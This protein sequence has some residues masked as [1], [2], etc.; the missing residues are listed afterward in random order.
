VWDVVNQFISLSFTQPVQTWQ[1]IYFFVSWFI[2][3]LLINLPFLVEN[4]FV[5]PGFSV[6]SQNTRGHV[7]VS[8]GWA[9][10]VRGE[11][12]RG[13]ASSILAA[14]GQASGQ[15]SSILADGGQASS[16]LADGGQASSAEAQDWRQGRTCF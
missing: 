8:L 10:A 5:D 7:G 11:T 9:T 14:G 6:L 16:T 13:Q 12:I 1:C 4:L 2:C 15:A 3:Y